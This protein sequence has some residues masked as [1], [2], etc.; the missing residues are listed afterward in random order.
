MNRHMAEKTWR[1]QVMGSIGSYV[2]GEN[3]KLSNSLN[4]K[5]SLEDLNLY[6]LTKRQVLEEDIF[7]HF[8][9]FCMLNCTAV[10]I[11]VLRKTSWPRIA[12]GAFCMV[13]YVYLLF[14][15]PVEAWHFHRRALSTD[16]TY[17]QMIRDSYIARFPD[18]PKAELYKKVN[19][20]EHKKYVELRHRLN[21]PQ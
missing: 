7:S 5:H 12:F 16:K 17:A 2:R 21:V 4:M 11:F 13:E 8:Y 6:S 14:N 19:A 9:P 3:I 10:T 15:F 1:M 18:T 20:Q